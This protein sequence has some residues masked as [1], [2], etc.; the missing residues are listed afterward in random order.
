LPRAARHGRGGASLDVARPS[1]IEHDPAT[2]ALQ[3]DPAAVAEPM[4]RF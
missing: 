4:A 1:C 3:R 2:G